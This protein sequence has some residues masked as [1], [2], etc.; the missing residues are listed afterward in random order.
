[1]L[2]A[3]DTST[4]LEAIGCQL[5]STLLAAMAAG[6][7]AN[8]TFMFV[9]ATAE[10]VYDIESFFRQM[11]VAL[12]PDMY[13]FAS[14]GMRR[15]VSQMIVAL[16]ELAPPRQQAEAAAAAPTA[17]AA[18]AASTPAPSRTPPAPP[19]PVTPPPAAPSRNPPAPPPPVSA[20]EPPEKRSATATHWKDVLN[21]V[22]D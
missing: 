14:V 19:P 8:S 12:H 18:P 11:R 21:D 6:A 4:W 15:A 16:D 10:T 20:N 13:P 17:P 5:H 22:S 7:W 1:M 3:H 9:L 2:C